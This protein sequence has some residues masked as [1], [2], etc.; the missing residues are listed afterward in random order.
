MW[1]TD[2]IAKRLTQGDLLEAFFFFP[3]MNVRDDGVLNYMS[4][5]IQVVKKKK[6]VRLWTYSEGGANRI[7]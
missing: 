1:R 5:V 7:C 4:V 3:I 6:K 2:I